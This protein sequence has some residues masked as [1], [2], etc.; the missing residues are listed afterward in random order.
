MIA[1][2]YPEGDGPPAF[3]ATGS[4]KSVNPDRIILKK[5]ILTGYDF[6]RCNIF[7]VF[8]SLCYYVIQ[9]ITTSLAFWNFN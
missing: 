9:L 8:L 2:K 3:A 6:F 7:C 1:L 5:I 4:L